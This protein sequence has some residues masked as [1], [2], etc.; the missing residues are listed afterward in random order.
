MVLASFHIKNDLYRIAKLLENYFI[1]TKRDNTVISQN[2]KLFMK[3]IERSICQN[4]KCFYQMKLPF[5]K[6][7]SPPN[8]KFTVIKTFTYLKHRFF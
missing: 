2:Y 7:Q 3:T 4:E 8:N 5:I 6:E 1:E